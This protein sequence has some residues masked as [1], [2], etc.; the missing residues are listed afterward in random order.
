MVRDGNS[1]QSVP[2]AHIDSLWVWRSPIKRD[3]VFGGIVFGIVGTVL[4]ATAKSAGNGLCDSQACRD[5]NARISIPIWGLVS[6]SAGV[7]FGSLVGP[8]TSH[9]DRRYP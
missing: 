4:T 3:A 2:L 9:W 1:E 8:V 5:A 7:L 6:A